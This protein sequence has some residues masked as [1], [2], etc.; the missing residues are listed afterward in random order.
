MTGAL[1]SLQ[2]RLPAAVADSDLILGTSAGSVLAAALRCRATLE[3]MAAWQCGDA[4]GL[5][6]ES[7]GL[8]A[9]DSPLPPLPRL[10]VGSLPLA[11]AGL[12]RPCRVPPWVSAAAWIPQG[13]AQHS[14]VR[15]LVTALQ[16]RQHRADGPEG[17][18]P[19]WPGGR[20]W[21]AAVDYDRGQRVLFGRPGAPRAP[22]PEAVVASCSVPGWYQPA[23]IG[24]RR[25]VD[26][27]VRSL[28]SLGAL[29]GT[30][31]S[32]IL[33]LAPLASTEPGNPLLPH[34]RI[35]RRLL[36]LATAALLRQAKTLAAQGKHVTIVTPGPRDLAVIGANPMDPRRRSAVLE[37]AVHTTAAALAGRGRTGRAV[38][39]AA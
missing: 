6:G 27:G 20:T 10:R 4:A 19:P 28:T 2:D 33:V 15:S 1:S 12:L 9:R 26:G 17:E 5:L 13:R 36:Q 7:A 34:L 11:A 22:L 30:D 37:T 23:R 21:I 14:A 24:G 25:Y 8:A 18:P 16:A 32:D 38:R 29:R 39:P 35:G 3:E 31:V